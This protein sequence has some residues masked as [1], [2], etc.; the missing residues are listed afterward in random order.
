VE[1]L[2][3]G[4]EIERGPGSGVRGIADPERDAV[5][6]ARLGR[7]GAGFGDR[8]LVQV[9]P[10][11]PR[12]WIG[13]GERNGGRAKAA[14]QVEHSRRRGGAEPP[15]DVGHGGQPGAGE[16]VEEHRPVDRS[17][18]VSNLRAV[19]RVGDAAAGTVCLE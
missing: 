3:H 15:V 19:G 8:R 11:D 5:G 7:L 12:A 4:D 18:A 16:L 13:A 9:D 1:R 10:Q 2:E 6:H 14:A 17:D